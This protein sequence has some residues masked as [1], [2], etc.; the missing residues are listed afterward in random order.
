[1]TTAVIFFHQNISAV[2]RQTRDKWGDLTAATLYT[3]VPT[4]FVFDTGR[5]RSIAEDER[6]DALAYIGPEWI[7]QPDDIMVYDGVDYMVV[8]VFR[9]HD[10]FGNVDHLK[11]TLRARS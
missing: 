10:L 5:I 6:V 11:I 7:I 8:K 4:R 1:M 3:G 2:K 9:E